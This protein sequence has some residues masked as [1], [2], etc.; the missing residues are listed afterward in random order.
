[1]QTQQNSKLRWVR[2]ALVLIVNGCLTVSMV[3]NILQTRAARSVDPVVNFDPGPPTLS[4]ALWVTPLVVGIILEFISFRFA[5]AVNVGY[6]VL[7]AMY[8][9]IG[10]FLASAHILGFA[11]PEHWITAVVF[12]AFPS[13]IFAV[14]LWWLYRRTR[15]VVESG[16]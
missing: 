4:D 7:I 13:G 3:I 12:M 10:F 6:Y 9:V 8:I 5:R 16:A 2:S 11:E 15:P 14:L 1:M